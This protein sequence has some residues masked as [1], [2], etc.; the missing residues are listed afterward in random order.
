MSW[1]IDLQAINGNLPSELIEQLCIIAGKSFTPSRMS[2]E[3]HRPTSM[4]RIHHRR[5]IIGGP[6]VHVVVAHSVWSG[7]HPVRVEERRCRSY[8]SSHR[9][10]WYSLAGGVQCL[11]PA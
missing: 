7:G 5:N 4:S 6:Q 8:T 10:A 1:I 3:T 9:L 11:V 2:D